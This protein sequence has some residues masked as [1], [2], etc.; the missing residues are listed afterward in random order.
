[1]GR[2]LTT[3]IVAGVGI[4]KAIARADAAMADGAGGTW[5]IVKETREMQSGGG[6]GQEIG[7]RAGRGVTGADA[8]RE[9][10]AGRGGIGAI[11]RREREASVVGIATRLGFGQ[12]INIGR[13]RAVRRHLGTPITDLAADGRNIG[14]VITV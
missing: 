5:P 1:M 11:V 9:I 14:G 3:R 8:V 2:G 12:R 10:A 4:G 13:A 6:I 7:A